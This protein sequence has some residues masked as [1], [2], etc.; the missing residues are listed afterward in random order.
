MSKSFLSLRS[1]KTKILLIVK[2]PSDFDPNVSAVVD[3][4]VLFRYLL[5]TL[6]L[7]DKE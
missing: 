5:V 6:L 3:S 7:I 2:Y 1:E 4:V